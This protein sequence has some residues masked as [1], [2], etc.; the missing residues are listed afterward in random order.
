MVE[1]NHVTCVDGPDGLVAV[2]PPG[3]P[4]VIPYYRSNGQILELSDMSRAV[5]SLLCGDTVAK[6]RYGSSVDGSDWSR[7][8]T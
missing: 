8:V 2:S 4:R 6:G 3:A 7:A 5:T 1:R